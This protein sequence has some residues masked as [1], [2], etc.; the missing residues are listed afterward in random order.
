MGK[1]IPLGE[2]KSIQSLLADMM[3]DDPAPV[4][5]A[6]VMFDD[7]GIPTWGCFGMNH[8]EVAYAALIMQRVALSD[9]FT[10]P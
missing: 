3:S 8:S 10:H 9:D 6:I 7:A 2:H 1:V 4:K 5:C